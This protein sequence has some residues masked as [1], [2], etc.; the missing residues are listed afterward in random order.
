MTRITVEDTLSREL[1]GSAAPVELCDP[2]GRVIG[3]FFPAVSAE[4]VEPAL[5]QVS[6][7]ELNR[8]QHSTEW[9]TTD[10]VLK[11]LEAK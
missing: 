9:H 4:S 8:R 5:P 3:R 6:E 7:E 2:S 10:D 1:E 11:R